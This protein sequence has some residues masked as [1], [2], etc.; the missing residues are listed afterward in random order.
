MTIAALYARYSTTNQRETSIADQL[1]LGRARCVAEGW[2]EPLTFSDPE[3]SASTPIGKRPGGRDMLLAAWAGR[4]QV[5]VIE[6]LDRAWRDLVDQE[7]TL[8][9]LE[10]AGIRVIGLVDGYD[11]QA[12]H[13]EMYRG[14]RGLFNQQYLRDIGHKTHR[15]LVGQLTRGYHAGGLAYG[16]RTVP[17]GERGHRLQVV[18]EQA[19]V[20]RWIF[21]QYAA[22]W[23]V[24]RI[25]HDLNARGV[26]SSRGGT[27]AVSALYGRSD[28]GTGVLNNELYIGRVVWNRA[29]FVKDP[30]TA[31]RV[32]IDRPREEWIIRE[33]PEL[34]IVDDALW[35]RAHARMRAPT[36]EGGRGRGAR[37]TTLFG[38]LLRCALCGGAVVA[39][40]GRLYG[41]AARK[42]RG[43]A[44][45]AGVFAPRESVDARL[46][47]TV[48]DQLLAPAAIAEAQAQF[49]AALKALRS[50]HASSR[51]ADERR[52]REL[53]AEIRRVVDAI[54]QVGVSA[55]LAA[56]LQALEAEQA[57][58]QA[59]TPV[60]AQAVHERTIEDALAR[61]KRQVLDLQAALADDLPRARE[62]LRE[63]LGEITL[64]EDR[65]GVFAEIGQP[66]QR[67]EVAAGGLSTGLVAGTRFCSQR[68]RVA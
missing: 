18:E 29:Q 44:V 63:L 28:R 10:F 59:R 12:E 64:S 8:R 46:L 15:G 56:R 27:W 26:A 13:R 66:G 49:A 36:R 61:Y 54:A 24:Q 19:A 42:D 7:Q 11:S 16:Y 68:L 53:E 2:G 20:V 23:S 38:G 52:R 55:A 43:P 37:P 3:I 58:L 51:A 9:R 31:K 4:F 48:R 62:L 47:A 45:C 14:M 67:Q 5:L 21:E 33:A 30:T 35:Q 57:T 39:V 25:A 65:E 41:C 34:R 17:D 40:S 6:A 50:D 1:R 22:G 32:R 60:Q